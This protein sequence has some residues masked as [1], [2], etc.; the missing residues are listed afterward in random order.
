M[1]K[2]YYEC[3]ITIEGEP[4][5]RHATQLHV[6]RLGWK[7]S[8]IDGDIVMGDGVKYYATRHFNARLDEEA[9]IGILMGTAMELTNQGVKV[10]RRKVERVLFDDR[11]SK[12]K[13]CDGACP[14]CHLDD[15]VPTSDPYAWEGFWPGCGSINSDTRYTR[16]KQVAA[17]W[18]KDGATVTPL[19]R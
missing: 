8:A 16:L 13:P 2:T 15:M 5:H 11:S 14:E 17:R 4:Q 6:E 19:Y 9:V 18:A 12:V 10:T 7:F 3:H 1:S